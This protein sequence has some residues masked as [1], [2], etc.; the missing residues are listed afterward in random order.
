MEVLDRWREV[1]SWWDEDR[2]TDRFVFRVLLS[3]DVV[4]DL[5]RERASGWELLGVVD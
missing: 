5:A 4:V 2:Y 1:E 3:G